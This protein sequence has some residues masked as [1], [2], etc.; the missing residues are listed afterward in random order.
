MDYSPAE[1]DSHEDKDLAHVGHTEEDNGGSKHLRKPVPSKVP[2][3]RYPKQAYLYLLTNDNYM[4]HLFVMEASFRDVETTRRRIALVTPKVTE[5]A[6]ATLRR[7]GIEVRNISQPTHPNF[8]V[9]FPRWA[10]MLAKFAI[11]E[12]TD[13][14]KFVYFDTDYIVN[15]NLDYLFEL[16]TDNMVYSM[17]DGI[18]CK[19]VAN[20]VNAGLL[21]AKP[22]PD[23]RANL[24][25]LLEN[26]T[27]RYGNGE[28]DMLQDYLTS[29]YVPTY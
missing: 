3:D 18:E 25:R 15:A 26:P 10:D 4:T 17:L 8:K 14:D 21:V 23:T 2:V 29:K 9:D 6:R 27:R 20:K 16:P 19:Q 24:F 28:Q 13:L 1:S 11:F 7:L 22:D 5:G 12:Q